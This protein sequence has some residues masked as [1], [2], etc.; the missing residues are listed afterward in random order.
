MARADADTP[1]S[2]GFMPYIIDASLTGAVFRERSH[3]DSRQDHRSSP[4]R[5]PAGHPAFW[6]RH[7]RQRATRI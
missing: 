3:V 7:E 2:A 5:R 4:R 1:I 6:V